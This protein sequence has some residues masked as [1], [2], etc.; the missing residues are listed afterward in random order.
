MG[1]GGALTRTQLRAQIQNGKLTRKQ[2]WAPRWMLAAHAFQYSTAQNSKSRCRRHDSRVSAQVRRRPVVGPLP[3]VVP[4]GAPARKRRAGR[5][6]RSRALRLRHAVRHEGRGVVRD[7][8]TLESLEEA[9]HLRERGRRAG[10]AIVPS[11]FRRPREPG[12]LGRGCVLRRRRRVFFSSTNFGRKSCRAVP[13]VV[14]PGD[15]PRGDER[16]TR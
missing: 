5:R 14:H 10:C 8:G 9:A 13:I 15:A 6:D 16:A 12:L 3:P 2:L 4:R 1:R 7:A 11:C